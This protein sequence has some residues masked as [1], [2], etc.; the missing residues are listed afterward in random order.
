MSSGIDIPHW[1]KIENVCF[2]DVNIL[3][4]LNT[5]GCVQFHCILDRI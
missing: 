4:S 3:E 2:F 1:K 5:K